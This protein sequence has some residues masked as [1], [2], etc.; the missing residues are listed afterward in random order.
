MAANNAVEGHGNTSAI[1]LNQDGYDPEA[2]NEALSKYLL[3]TCA[4][5]SA[6]VIVWRL[7]SIA[8]RH[9]RTMACLQNDTQR[10]FAVESSNL[11]LVKKHLLYAP[12]FRK[13]H[14]REFQLSSAITVGTLPTR[15]QLLFLMGYVA[16]NVAFCVISI[17]FAGS[18]S[19]AAAILR[20]RSG[21][22][23]VVNM[24]PL[25]LM[26]GRNNPLIDI[27]GISFD[28]FN[29]LHRWFGRIAALEMVA[30]SVAFLASQASTR[31][32]AAAL[33]TTTSSPFLLYGFIV[34]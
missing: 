3:V 10:Y 18:F 32:L 19:A 15:F 34:S 23:A 4:S 20:D 1:G 22:L 29:L 30:H 28:T 9:L 26:A 33:Q 12:I 31:G 27:L 13:R 17:P 16:T 11:S 6:A 14:N 2:E 8:L 21:S 5:L 7:V 24:I 25:F